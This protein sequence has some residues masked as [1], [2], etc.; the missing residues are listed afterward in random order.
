MAIE[1]RSEKT[2][3]SLHKEFQSLLDKDLRSAKEVKLLRQR[4]QKNIS[5]VLMLL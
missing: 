2:E 4:L 5:I 1:Q 3:S